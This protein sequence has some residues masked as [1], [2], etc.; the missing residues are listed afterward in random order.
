MCSQYLG[1]IAIQ[2][3][4]FLSACKNN[5]VCHNEEKLLDFMMTASLRSISI[6]IRSEININSTIPKATPSGVSPNTTL[7]LKEIPASGAVAWH[8]V[9]C[10][11]ASTT[12]LLGT[13]PAF[14]KPS[15]TAKESTDSYMFLLGLPYI[16]RVITTGV[17]TFTCAAAQSP[18]PAS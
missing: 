17:L 1:S 13:L 10:Y 2:S 18:R 4:V 9:I 3:N 15:S 11:S 14:W 8:H 6:H 5:C 12:A 16:T 7:C